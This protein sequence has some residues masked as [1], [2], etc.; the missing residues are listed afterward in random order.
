MHLFCI[1]KQLGIYSLFL[2]QILQVPIAVHFYAMTESVYSTHT[3]YVT[4]MEIVQ[5]MKMKTGVI[6]VR[7]GEAPVLN[8]V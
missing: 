5:V 7:S 8:K 6:K 3:G 4:G 2:W 1:S